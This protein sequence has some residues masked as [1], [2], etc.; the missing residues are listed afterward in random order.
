[1]FNGQPVLGGPTAGQSTGPLFS[2]QSISDAP[3]SGGSPAVVPSLSEAGAPLT[4]G[5]VTSPG[6]VTMPQG[7]LGGP[8]TYGGYDPLSSAYVPFGP[9]SPETT[10][11]AI[12]AGN[13]S[14]APDGAP[15]S[16]PY[17]AN[18]LRHFAGYTDTGNGVVQTPRPPPSL[19]A[20]VAKGAATFGAGAV[21]GPAFGMLANVIGNSL[22]R[23]GGL[24]N[25]QP[26]RGPTGGNYASAG[27][28]PWG[29]PQYYT[30]SSYSNSPFTP[31]GYT[32]P[33]FSP[34]SGGPTYAYQPNGQGGGTYID[35]RGNVHPY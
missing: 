5:E 25:A 26:Y 2:K 24:D 8:P 34:V 20:R 15:G 23:S 21:G 11:G 7:W 12:A 1:M 14:G 9:A 4:P 19:G 30:G 13:V 22:L 6:V 27:T 32:A 31:S 17:A 18:P 3:Y 10:P 29:T 16:V 35:S 28:T 33:N